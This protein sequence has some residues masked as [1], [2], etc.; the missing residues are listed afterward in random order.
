MNTDNILSYLF[1]AKD[2]VRDAKAAAAAEGIDRDFD[3]LINQVDQ[4]IYAI[5]T[6]RKGM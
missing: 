5:Q 2:C 3:E 1:E 6:A 4:F